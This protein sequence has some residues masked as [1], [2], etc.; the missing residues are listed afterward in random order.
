MAHDGKTHLL[1]T[2]V[3]TPDKV[4]AIDRLVQSHRAWMGRTHHREGPRALLSYN[5]SKGPE[6]SSPLD[7]SSDPTGDTRY[8]LDE[9]YDSEAGIADHWAQAP[10][11]WE[12]FGEFVE[13]L[14]GCDPQTLHA[15]TVTGSL[16]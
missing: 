4:D 1:I 14:S 3:A 5:F 7:P 10:T 2:F 15:G 9:I 6:L 13:I 11:S 16:W 8:V 12:D